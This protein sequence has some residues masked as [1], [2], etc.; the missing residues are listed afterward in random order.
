MPIIALVLLCL[1]CATILATVAGIYAN[2]LSPLETA[3]VA[4][5]GYYT[6]F[7]SYVYVLALC[8]RPGSGYEE[9][10]PRQSDYTPH[11]AGAGGGSLQHGA[12][13]YGHSLDD[14][15]EDDE[16][17]IELGSVRLDDENAL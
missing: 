3:A 8:F 12:G 9:D 11:A 4:F 2:V 7:N 13:E 14:D 5:L 15:E 10:R 6:L 1:T 17:E 16:Q